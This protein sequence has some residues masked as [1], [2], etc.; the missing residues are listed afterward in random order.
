LKL[1]QPKPLSDPM[2]WMTKFLVPFIAAFV[3]VFSYYTR[4]DY[5]FPVLF[6]AASL[7]YW[8]FWLLPLKEVKLDNEYLII[9]NGIKKER[10]S[11]DNIAGLETGRKPAFFTRIYFKKKTKFGKSVRF[12]AFTSVFDNDLTEETKNLLIQLKD[13]I[14]HAEGPES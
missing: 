10:V 3:L 12:A 14:N 11:L 7:F 6:S 13:R 9:S 8:L 5:H 1:D 2:M 4:A